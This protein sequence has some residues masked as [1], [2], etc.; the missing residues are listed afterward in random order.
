MRDSTRRRFKA[1]VLVALFMVLVL[2]AAACSSG[3]DSDST[4]SGSGSAQDEGTPESGGTLTYAL[5]G[6]T[7]NFC[8]PEA[9]LAI[10]GILVVEAVYDT[11]TR[12]TQDPLVYEP[13]LAK[14]VTPNDDFT[15]WTIEIREGVEFHDGTPLTAEIVKQNLDAW[16]DGL[17]LGFI[18]ENVADVAIVDGTVVITMTTP[19]VAFPAY[20]WNTGRT[21]VAAPAQLD[22]EDCGTDLI[23]TGPFS[24]NS[25]D[26][27]TGNLETVKNESYWREGF[28]YLDGINFI[29]QGESSQRL[30][31]LEGGEF[32]AIMSNGGQDIARVQDISNTV[33]QLEPDGRQEVSQ[34]LINVTRPPLDDLDARLAVAMAVDREEL[35]IVDQA[36]AARLANQVFDTD[37]MGFLEDPGA[38]EHDP[39]AARELVEKVKEKNGGEFAFTIATTFDQSTQTLFQEVQRQL[40]EFGIDVTLAQPVD[41][42]TLISNAIGGTNDAFGWRNYPGQD[43]DTMYV[44][45]YGGSVVNFNKI[46]DEIVND[47]LDGGRAESDPDKRREFYETFN[48]QMNEQA[49]TLWTWYTQWFVAHAPEVHG[50]SGPNLP[51]PDAVGGAP[52]DKKPV[53]LL[54]GY[55]Q[56]LG[57]WMSSN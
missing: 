38:P 7:T 20:L 12:P 44:W 48:R 47:A 30:N 16:R 17:L 43:P 1:P 13:Y 46:D 53:D 2:V 50:I 40:A 24:V 10:S 9:Q 51:N 27:T 21:G 26:P 15:E 42:A 36:G 37:I 3:S 22:G 4:D 56:M 54:A 18:F 6:P 19:W 28:P 29:V 23:G 34:M 11:L 33:V 35:N 57:I 31:G 39:D 8:L 45:F 55:H 5:E 25:F 32:N 52:G 14:S 49:Y 41:Q